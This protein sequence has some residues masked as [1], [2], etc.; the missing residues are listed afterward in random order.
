MALAS[1]V[2][3]LLRHL[4][5]TSSVWRDRLR[6][7]VTRS[8]LD[9]PVLL[10]HEPKEPQLLKRAW[11]D[12]AA[13]AV[14]G[15]F[16]EPLRVGGCV[17]VTNKDT[18]TT[19]PDAAAGPI[20]RQ[21]VIIEL[22]TQF[23][24]A[25]V[26]YRDC[27]KRTTHAVESFEALR[28]V[29]EVVLGPAFFS[30]QYADLLA[31]SMFFLQTKLHEPQ[32]DEGGRTNI[33]RS[34]DAIYTQMKSCSVIA[35]ASLL[36]NTAAVSLFVEK[37]GLGAILDLA[38]KNADLGP[39]NRSEELSEAQRERLH[40]IAHTAWNDT[41][42]FSPYSNVPM[43]L[44]TAWHGAQ[45]RNM[46]IGGSDDAQLL[47]DSRVVVETG[48]RT[49]SVSSA[50]ADVPI[51]RLLPMFYFEVL[52]SGCGGSSV[53]VG[54]SP[55]RQASGSTST[56]SSAVG[57]AKLECDYDTVY[58]YRGDGVKCSPGNGAAPYGYSFGSGDIVGCGWNR[59]QATIFFTHNGTLLQDAFTLD[60]GLGLELY[61]V[62]LHRSQ[63]ARITA[64]F[65][66]QPFCFDLYTYMAKHLKRNTNATSSS[67][68]EVVVD[69]FG[70]DKADEPIPRAAATP[71]QELTATS[72]AQAEDSTASASTAETSEDVKTSTAEENKE[73]RPATASTTEQLPTPDSATQPAS[74]ESSV[75]TSSASGSASGS[76]SEAEAAAPSATALTTELLPAPDSVT[77]PVSSA[78]FVATASE[79]RS[80]SESES[81]SE[82]ES[83]PSVPSATASE[84]SSA[85][86]PSATPSPSSGAPVMLT[87]E[88]SSESASIPSF[89]SVAF[90][91]SE[92]PPQQ[93]KTV[94]LPKGGRGVVAPTRGRN[95]TEDIQVGMWYKVFKDTTSLQR[96][97]WNAA[98]EKTIGHS[99]LVKALNT[100]NGTAL[101]ELYDP[102]RGVWQEWWYPQRFLRRPV[103]NVHDPWPHTR[104]QMLIL[105]QVHFVDTETA[106]LRKYAGQALL[107]LL[108]HWPETMRFSFESVGDHSLLAFLKYVAAEYLTGATPSDPINPPDE[109][110]GALPGTHKSRLAAFAALPT[111]QKPGRNAVLKVVSTEIATRLKLEADSSSP[112]GGGLAH[113]LLDHC[114]AAGFWLAKPAQP[115]TP[116][117]NFASWL[118][119]L[120]YADCAP[121]VKEKYTPQVF[122]HLASHLKAGDEATPAMRVRLIR[123]MMA[124]ATD[125]AHSLQG[126]P[127]A[128]AR[129]R[130]N[131]E[132]TDWLSA[133]MH[134]LHSEFESEG[135]S[136]DPDALERKRFFSTVVELL[137]VLRKAKW[138]YF[139]ESGESNENKEEQEE[140]LTL[141]NND[142]WFD[143][144]VALQSASE[145][146]LGP[147][148]ASAPTPLLCTAA[149]STA[150]AQ[151]R[152]SETHPTQD[153]AKEKPTAAS[154]GSS[155]VVQTLPDGGEVQ[156]VHIPGASSLQ[157]VLDPRCKLHGTDKLQFFRPNDDDRTRVGTKIRQN[158]PW[159]YLIDGD[160]VFYRYKRSVPS[161]NEPTP[162]S[163][164]PAAQSTVGFGG[165]SFAPPPFG[166]SASTSGFSF[167]SSSG[168]AAPATASPAADQ[169]TST[170][171]PSSV[172]AST[173]A[174]SAEPPKSEAEQEPKESL[175]EQVW[176]F[177]FH[178]VPAFN[179][180]EQKQKLA[181]PEARA[182]VER[183]RATL[184]GGVKGLAIDA[185]LVEYV[186]RLRSECRIPY[187]ALEPFRLRLTDTERLVYTKLANITEEEMR[188]RVMMLRRFNEALT[189]VLPLLD[190]AGADR[191]T[192]A[193]S[194]IRL[195]PLIFTQVKT[196]FFKS[197]YKAMQSR[198]NMTITINR[199][200]LTDADK[201]A[202]KRKARDSR[203]S[204]AGGDPYAGDD[205][206]DIQWGI[207]TQAFHQ[208]HSANPAQLRSTGRAFTV[209]LVGEGATDSGGPYRECLS[210]MCAELQSNQL[211]LFIPCPNA[212]L[213]LEEVGIGK[214]RDKY[215]PK[216]S[217]QSSLHLAMYEFVGKL[218]G[219]A[220]RTKAPLPLDLPSAVWKPLVG[221]SLTTDDLKDID[222][223]CG[224][225]LDQLQN[226]EAYDLNAENFSLII[227]ENFTTALSDGSKVE[228]KE[229]GKD[230]DV[231]YENRLEYV[232]LVRQR[233]LVESRAQVAAMRRGLA[234]MVPID[235]LS[236]FTW[237]ELELLVCGKPDIDVEVLKQ[238]VRYEG[239]HREDPTVAMLWE[240][241]AE[242]S[243][244][245][246]ALFL[247]FVSGRERLATSKSQ[248]AFTVT[249]LHG[250][251]DALPQSATCFFT[252]KLPAYASR[253]VLKH[254]LLLAICNCASIDADFQVRQQ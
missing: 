142:S 16:P 178:V 205:D 36:A 167:G 96:K 157:V 83:A 98:M 44:P 13:L 230:I 175:P 60:A 165:F 24:K 152:E 109:D 74:S 232:N 54:L 227:F 155:E 57:P 158:K 211:P 78:S 147:D 91:F 169:P 133:T 201:E 22:D 202:E 46:Q 85:N 184:V 208:L 159:L 26:V 151:C 249:R 15:G 241:V 4:L 45:L 195:R 38:L 228:L 237:E 105:T 84:T 120:V 193:A 97:D 94:T 43:V 106:L 49:S 177:A 217:S 50:C 164:Q 174:A 243:P 248:N 136:L 236:L 31:V 135:Q 166:A 59:D 125:C 161:A 55:V 6:E 251:T 220:I 118:I 238:H 7:L 69:R 51:S 162:A 111:S 18:T 150:F 190:L 61:P 29:P 185:E 180:D 210:S 119:A 62:L 90:S 66:Q 28:A 181:S 70:L 141:M 223:F 88:A 188:V 139:E 86:D 75:V 127:E 21:G 172:S 173:E 203:A 171:E 234:A 254:K 33:L 204:A 213:A 117:F 114:I 149:L 196:K 191:G 102:E 197:C 189:T 245:E 19:N 176:G 52:L 48:L 95:A 244:K 47:F 250:S 221:Q 233:R 101:L 183:L 81:E 79:S 104:K 222:Q 154:E 110:Q 235:A 224:Q 199:L 182:E 82:E 58:T 73:E 194:L 30:P 247:R 56:A 214:N 212:Q 246:R 240:T 163:A 226:P 14:V 112:S 99:G 218:M 170:A 148:G 253:E 11:R 138:D 129:A 64:N 146:W 25:K 231:T 168:P 130:P 140:Q 72:P 2:I 198:G 207:F 206:K 115:G 225:C 20:Y 1:E 103:K 144:L 126:S 89:G 10:R 68:H 123:F 209:R 239:F 63:G 252:L 219:I 17:E 39:M 186:N 229:G 87:L 160:T 143:T 40:S 35:L 215:I 122:E 34:W 242:F 100:T 77:T 187:H 27:P 121:S 179:E 145:W 5:N 53:E 192:L 8:A 41:V 3:A 131:R 108:A 12:L 134:A 42:P 107:S 71:A 92:Q 116:D 67:N 113:V 200:L 76:A 156:K 37:G 137:V 23:R 128:L 32:P 153:A 132:T 93:R 65:G 216:P 9:A 80:D 124:L